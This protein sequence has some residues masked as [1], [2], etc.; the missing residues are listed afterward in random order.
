MSLSGNL[1]FV[2]LDEVLRLLSRSKQRGAVNVRG[3]VF[4]GRV[5]IGTEGISLATTYDDANLKRHLTHAQVADESLLS[6]IE[7]GH[8]AMTE[9]GD[10]VFLIEL[11]REMTVESIYQMGKRG[12]DF[13]VYEGQTTPYGS[14]QPFDLEAILSD[15][16]RRA[17]DWQTVSRLVPDLGSVIRFERDLGTRE[18]VSVDADAWKVL[19][20][21]GFGSSVEEIADRLGTT[22]FWTARVAGHL[23]ED[24]L[25]ANQVEEE[26]PVVADGPA[27]EAFTAWEADTAEWE[28][29]APS[30][31]GEAI[32]VDPDQSWWQEPEDDGEPDTDEETVT[33][34]TPTEETTEAA[35]ES[36]F[37]RFAPGARKS[38]TEPADEIA[39]SDAVVDE[40]PV[41][42]DAQDTAEVEE[43][44]EAFLEKV[45]SELESADETES[46]EEGYGLLR[47]RR[48]GAIRDNSIDS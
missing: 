43:D 27:E 13:E 38:D 35:S 17:D 12:L 5:F 19:S 47:R 7:A 31:N 40:A 30:G 3:D 26:T 9:M 32:Q 41:V 42:A 37:G 2:S 25:L 29:E 23:I 36:M 8:S 20:E 18:E 10:S 39:E 15:S 21:V 44:T 22:E 6:E 24:S 45:F 16:A 46:E 1:G 33:A 34:E 28:P 11:L 48:M 4:N 14:P